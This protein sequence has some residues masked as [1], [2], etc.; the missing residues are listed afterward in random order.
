MYSYFKKKEFRL[1]NIDER[2]IFFLEEAE[3]DKLMS[4]KHKNVCTI[5]NYFG[6]FLILAS[7]V[8]GCISFSAFASMIGIPI[9]IT[10]SATGLKICTITPRTISQYY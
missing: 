2:R 1:K 3:Q 5:S 8:I 4:N 10:S 9:G 7:A 6:H